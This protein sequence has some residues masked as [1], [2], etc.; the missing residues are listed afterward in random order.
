MKRARAANRTGVPRIAR[1]FRILISSSKSAGTTRK[2]FGYC[3]L[4]VVFFLKML[5][6]CNIRLRSHRVLS[7]L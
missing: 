2:V 4:I 1:Y 6:D 5:F 3:P 7:L